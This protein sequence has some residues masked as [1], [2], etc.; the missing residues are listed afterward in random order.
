LHP[1]RFPQL[2]DGVRSCI[3]GGVLGNAMGGPFEDTQN[4]FNSKNTPT[5]PFPMI[6]N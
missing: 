1:E 4:R 2:A 5:G 6:R 3:I